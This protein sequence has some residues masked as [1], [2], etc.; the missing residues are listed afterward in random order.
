MDGLKL[1]S[2]Y[3]IPSYS[4]GF[5]GPQDKKSKKILT[6]FSL[7]KP[8]SKK[9]VRHIFAKFEAAYPYYRLIAK[10]NNL[11]DPLDE[12]V[13]RAFW[14]GNNLLKKCNQSDLQNLICTDFCRPGL[15]TKDQA[16]KKSAQVLKGAFPHHS[17]HVLVLGAV[18]AQ[19][20]V[21]GTMLDLCRISWGKVIELKIDPPAGG[22]KLKIIYKPL[23]LSNKLKLGAMVK[24]EIEWNRKIVPNVKIGNW[25]S[26]HWG[27]VCQVLDHKSVKNLQIYTKNSINLANAQS[28]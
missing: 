20:K 14:V 26:F 3:S 17:F 10:K 19:V 27:Q 25:V 18:S 15:L 1:A 11:P 23:T 22:G 7:G 2:V 5:C 4:L 28:K 8:V 12:K 16:K 21:K 13:V 6:S 24:K 9:L